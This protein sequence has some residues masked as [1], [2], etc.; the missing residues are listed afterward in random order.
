MCDMS[1]AVAQRWVPVSALNPTM[2]DR[3]IQ[4]FRPFLHRVWPC[5]SKFAGLKF[6]RRLLRDMPL[7][8]GIST[9][10]KQACTLMAKIQQQ[11]S[12]TEQPTT[13]VLEL[14]STCALLTSGLRD[15]P[16]TETNEWSQ[17]RQGLWQLACFLWVDSRLLKSCLDNPFSFAVTSTHAWMR[18]CS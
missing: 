15:T 1:A 7:P 3:G 13:I 11:P 18:T 16:L 4:K 2:S 14:V 12:S 9:I 8:D 17:L 6:V 5:L 10:L